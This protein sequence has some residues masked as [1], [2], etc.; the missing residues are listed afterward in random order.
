MQ[1]L[2]TGSVD[3][4]YLGCKF[5]SMLSQ[6]DFEKMALEIQDN[7]N[8]V[9]EHIECKWN[10]NSS[11]ECIFKLLLVREAWN[12]NAEI[13]KAIAENTGGLYTPDKFLQVWSFYDRA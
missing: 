8:G 13:C 10:E 5:P 9:V 4:V 11:N 3:Q 1:T 12:K 2:V 7:S 6:E